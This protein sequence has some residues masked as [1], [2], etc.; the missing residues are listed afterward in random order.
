MR[1]RKFH[2]WRIFL[3]LLAL[4]CVALAQ[5]EASTR[6]GRYSGAALPRFEALKADRVNLRRGPG[7][8]YA[9][10]WVL[11]REGLPVRVIGEHGH[12]RRVEL[13]DGERG[14]IHQALLSTRR[15][16]IF[17]DG[18]GELYATPASTGR[19]AAR[20]ETVTPVGLI[21]CALDWCRAERGGRRGW[22]PKRRLWGVGADDLF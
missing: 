16:A 7:L 11:K 3:P 6:V 19:L 2:L 18:V 8:D 21:E 15:T 13:H 4:A 20:V 12:W 14:W 9:I 5:A 10:L 1:D 22:A 17:V